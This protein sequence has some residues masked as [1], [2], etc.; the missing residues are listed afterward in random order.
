MEP[1]APML[2]TTMKGHRWIQDWQCGSMWSIILATWDSKPGPRSALTSAAVVITDFGRYMG[3]HPSWRRPGAARRAG[4][5]ET[6]DVSSEELGARTMKGEQCGQHAC[7]QQGAAF[8][9]DF[10]LV[11]RNA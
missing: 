7:Q 2:E 6:Q 3:E 11:L 10:D 5:P 4:I 8:P 1:V 9:M